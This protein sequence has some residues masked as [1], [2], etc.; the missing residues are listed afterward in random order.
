MSYS[1][2]RSVFFLFLVLP[3]FT[4]CLFCLSCLIL[5]VCLPAFLLV[6]CHSF[7]CFSVSIYRCF[8][9][10]L[11]LFLLLWSY[12]LAQPIGW[13]CWLMIKC[14]IRF[15]C[16]R[17][18]GIIFFQGEAGQWYN[19]RS[20]GEIEHKRSLFISLSIYLSDINLSNFHSNLLSIR[21]DTFLLG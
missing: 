12:S 1:N 15:P 6:W 4:S 18:K 5:C 13:A 10:Y 21:R 8:M 2:V 7:A 3:L 9:D 16:L 14:P 11:F 17:K 19:D 20:C